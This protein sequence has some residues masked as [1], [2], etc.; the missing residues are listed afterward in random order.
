MYAKDAREQVARW[1]A[2]RLIWTIEMGGF[3]PGYEQAIQMLA[4]EITR[5]YLDAGVPPNLSSTP[6]WRG[7]GEAAIARTDESSGGYSGMQ[8]GVAKLLALSWLQRGP[9]ATLKLVGQHRQIQAS[10]HWPRS[11]SAAKNT[12]ND[13]G[14]HVRN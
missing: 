9:E 12:A 7:F 2:G 14:N 3:G 1:D 11:S 5:D 6:V 10:A 4:I 13:E 8:V